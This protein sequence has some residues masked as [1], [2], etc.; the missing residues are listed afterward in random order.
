MNTPASSAG[1]KKF[2]SKNGRFWVA[3]ETFSKLSRR[4]KMFN[5]RRK[6]PA[7]HFGPA[8]EST[9]MLVSKKSENNRPPI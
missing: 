9:Y 3:G 5:A 1:E 6:S 4:R 8:N 7:E 2:R